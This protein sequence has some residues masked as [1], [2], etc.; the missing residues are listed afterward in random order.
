MVIQ[1]PRREKRKRI[2]VV[3]ALNSST[4]LAKDSKGFERTCILM[5][6]SCRHENNLRQ[7]KKPSVVAGNPIGYIHSLFPVTQRLQGFM[8]C[9]KHLWQCL[10]GFRSTYNKI[11]GVRI[12]FC[13][14]FFSQQRTV[15]YT[16]L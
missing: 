9:F 16:Y 4:L 8:I 13:W 2:I 7:G 15:T 10:F 3:E 6:S 14:R 11:A 1:H 12:R 5:H